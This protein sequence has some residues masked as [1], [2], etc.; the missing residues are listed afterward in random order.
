MNF[1]GFDTGKEVE[2]EHGDLTRVKKGTWRIVHHRARARKLRK[3]GEH[4]R[5]SVAMYLKSQIKKHPAKT[6][7]NKGCGFPL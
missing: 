4:I 2:D 3:R 1:I 5:W 6:V 7:T